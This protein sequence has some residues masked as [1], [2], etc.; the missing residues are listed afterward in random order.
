MPTVLVVDD[1]EF[2]RNW[3]VVALEQ[4]GFKAHGTDRTGDV[5]TALKTEDIDLAIIDY[6]MPGKD[7]LTL[8]RDIRAAHVST[9]VIILTGDANQAIAVECFRAGASDFISKPAD[10]DYLAIVVERAL[11]SHSRNL[12]NIAYRTLG[13]VQH[14]EGCAH[15]DNPKECTCGLTDVIS[16]IRSF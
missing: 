3:L 11:Q 8:L 16:S 6:H 14:R 15:Y 10:P 9:P 7:G 5:V 2:M 12:K 4:K 13:Y 1:E